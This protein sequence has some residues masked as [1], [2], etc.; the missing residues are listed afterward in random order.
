[1]SSSS[2]SAG[3]VA[4]LV[5]PEY[6]NWLAL[7]HALT[8]ELCQGLRAFINRETRSFYN[9]LKASLA[10]VPP[11]KCV[12]VPGRKPNRYHDM[13]KCVWACFLENHHDVNKPSWR[14]SDPTKWLDPNLGPW[15][16]AKRFLPDFGGHVEIHGAEDMDITSILNLM[17]WCTHFTVPQDLIKDVRDTRNSK[18]GHVP[19]LELTDAEKSIAF[20]A[21][22]NLLKD[23]SLAHEPDAQ[24]ALVEIGKLKIDSDLHSME[25]RVLVDLKEVIGKEI[26]RIDTQL[27]NLEE[28]SA[29]NKEER[30]QLNQQQEILTK[31][32]EEVNHSKPV[33]RRLVDAVFLLSG[34]VLVFQEPVL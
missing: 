19:D 24:K 1:M 28:E 30:N 10:G 20:D 32:L 17:Y 31:A 25:A 2:S 22:E 33:D 6:R 13:R 26:A 3:T 18:W 4:Q 27:T 21:I 16:I 11:C 8:T 12:D 7:G 29:R 15:E 5:K 14:Q 9:N 23:P 34:F